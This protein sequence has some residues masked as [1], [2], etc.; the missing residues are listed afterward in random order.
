VFLPDALERLHRFGSEV[1]RS[2]PGALSGMY[3]VGSLALGDYVPSRSNFD[4]LAV[5]DTAWAPERLGAA[6]KAARLLGNRHQ[7]P[8]VGCVTWSD[9]ADDPPGGGTCFEGGRVVEA[10]ELLNPLTW[11]V[12]RT[13]AVCARGPEYPELGRGELR[14]WAAARL[15]GHWAAWAPA[16]GR[17]PGALW[18]RRSA[19]EAVLEATRLV[20]AVRS[21]RVVSKLEAGTASLDGG[22]SRSRRILK[23]AIGYRSGSRTS[24]YWGPFERKEDALFHVQACV[25][26][27]RLA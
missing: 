6:R 8:R 15:A 10:T 9:L 13:A 5:S 17:R 24:M 2:A 1:D 7:P 16:A 21:G 27:A 20:V 25:D 22:S 19:T 18:L 14:A 11:Q 4:L 12:M 26:E 23:D 3:A